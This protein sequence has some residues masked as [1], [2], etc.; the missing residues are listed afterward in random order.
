MYF[1]NIFPPRMEKYDNITEYAINI[2]IKYD[3]DLLI[4]SDV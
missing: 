3:I 4:Y 1:D 2:K